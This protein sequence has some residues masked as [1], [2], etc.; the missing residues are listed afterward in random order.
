MS[1]SS[2]NLYDHIELSLP[3]RPGIESQR[4]SSISCFNRIYSYIQSQY[5]LI[6]Y[7][8][9]YLL[10]MGYAR[11]WFFNLFF[12]WSRLLIIILIFSLSY[13]SSK[14]PVAYRII[15]MG[16]FLQYH[17]CYSFNNRLWNV[18]LLP[19]YITIVIYSMILVLVIYIYQFKELTVL[20]TRT[21]FAQISCGS[22]F[23][24]L[25]V[26]RAYK[27]ILGKELFTPAVFITCIVMH[28]HFFHRHQRQLETF[29]LSK[30][31]SSIRILSI[32]QWLKIRFDRMKNLLWCLCELHIY[33]IVLI[34]VC[35]CFTRPANI[36]ITNLILLIIF[37]MSLFV[38]V[39]Q[40]IALGAYA[41]VSALQI[42]MIMIV[43][44]ELFAQLGYV[45][46]VCSSSPS[47]EK[48][49]ADLSNVNSSQLVAPLQWFGL[50]T[51]N[52][53][54]MTV[55]QSILSCK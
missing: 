50:W 32:I 46:H 29:D 16:F 9:H 48:Y 18:Y 15:Y 44:L 41:V 21:C 4:N 55:R 42:L 26:H 33:K 38:S 36:C 1:S 45:K 25:G 28:I 35:V 3:V 39:L 12:N 7:E 22:L 8:I 24:S 14:S 54:D 43:R 11:V 20:K 10:Y 17:L 6:S 47:S 51:Q 30:T 31:N 52:T 49:E 40:R 27:N 34:I 53:S 13:D 23:S 2:L 37:V 19:F 5:S